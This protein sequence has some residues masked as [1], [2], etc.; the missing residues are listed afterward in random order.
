M[1]VLSPASRVRAEWLHRAGRAL[2]DPQVLMP[3]SGLA[4][5]LPNILPARPKQMTQRA[6]RG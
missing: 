6:I 4:W 2:A 5:F 3:L 1:S